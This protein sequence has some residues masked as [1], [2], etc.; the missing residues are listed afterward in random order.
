MMATAFCGSRCNRRCGAGMDLRR[1]S[2]LRRKNSFLHSEET[3][4]SLMASRYNSGTVVRRRSL[5]ASQFST[6]NTRPLNTSGLIL[7]NAWCSLWRSSEGA[8]GPRRKYSTMAR[9]GFSLKSQGL[10]I[11]FT[12][13]DHPSTGFPTKPAQMTMAARFVGGAVAAYQ[14]ASGVENDSATSTNCSNGGTAAPTIGRKS[15]YCK[16]LSVG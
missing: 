9:G 14:T 6:S 11:A 12:T 16:N 13:P 3:S 8:C 10:A 7:C 1:V 4:L 2:R 15:A 5:R